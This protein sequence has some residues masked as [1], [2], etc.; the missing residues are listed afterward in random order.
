LCLDLD[1]VLADF[2]ARA[3]A[4]C[5]RRPDAMR[6]AHL[7]AALAA[8]PNFFGSLDPTHDAAELWAFAGPY[9]PRIITGSPRG[10]WAAPQKRAWVARVLGADVHVTVCAA[11]DKGRHARPG[12]VLV[13]DMAKNAAGWRAGGGVFVLHTSAAASIAALREMGF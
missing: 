6:P 13:D 7:W 2:D 3:L 8:H 4:I 11:R 1:G 5:G 12:D 9:R 10:T